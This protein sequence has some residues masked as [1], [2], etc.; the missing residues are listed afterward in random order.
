MHRWYNNN[1]QNRVSPPIL[2]WKDLLSFILRGFKREEHTELIQKDLQRRRDD[3]SSAC[4]PVCKPTGV[5][6]T[7]KILLN[8]HCALSFHSYFQWTV[9]SITSWEIK[10]FGNPFISHF[11]DRKRGALMIRTL[12]VWMVIKRF[13]KSFHT[14]H[15]IVEQ[16]DDLGNI[17]YWPFIFK[18]TLF[19]KGRK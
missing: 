16:L 3:C 7:L 11:R 13:L 18:E 10:L 17:S 5:T 9:W 19:Y 4:S 2:N 8:S 6:S 15:F 1:I 12:Y 14:H